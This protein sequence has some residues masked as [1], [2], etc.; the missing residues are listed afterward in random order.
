MTKS[1]L[2]KKTAYEKGIYSLHADNF[3]SR[4]FKKQIK[5]FVRFL[6]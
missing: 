2:K 5:G 1:D 4:V 3:V 6:L